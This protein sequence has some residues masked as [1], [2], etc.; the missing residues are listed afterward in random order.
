VL[1]SLD[2]GFGDT[3]RKIKRRDHFETVL[4]NLASYS[5]AGAHIAAK[6]IMLP[7]NCSRHEIDEFVERIRWIG[8]REV[9]GDIDHRYPNSER[10]ITEALG[11]MWYACQRV[12]IPFRL[13]STG[14]HHN[15]ESGVDEL[16]AASYGMVANAGGGRF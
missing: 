10:E 1:C 5:R 14:L 9:L 16:V 2:A 8:V 7:A 3:Y 13:G 15:P 4:A 6:Y 11:Y 12:R